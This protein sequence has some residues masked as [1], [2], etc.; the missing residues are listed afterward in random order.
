MCPEECFA[1]TPRITN[2]LTIA[3]SKYCRSGGRQM[4]CSLAR[5]AF[6][7]L[8]VGGALVDAPVARADGPRTY[9][10]SGLYIGANAGYARGDVDVQ[11]EVPADSTGAYSRDVGGGLFGFHVGFQHQW[12]SLVFGVEGS[13][14]ASGGDKIDQRGPDAPA[15]PGFDSYARMNSLLMLGGRLGWT[16][17]SN[18]LLYGAG[19]WANAKVETSYIIT[20]I[21]IVADQDT[22]R[23]NG[24][25]VGGGVEY[26]L[27]QSVIVGV[28]YLHVDLDSKIHSPGLGAFTTRTV[29]PD[30]DIVRARISFKLGRPEAVE[31]LK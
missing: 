29:D 21:I 28:E 11:Y 3:R 18:W 7:L 10:W 24:F 15:F 19:G 31:P 20:P 4:T 1:D 17:R 16:P 6:M 22:E 13:Y 5:A 8:L 2:T 9:N 30:I 12:Q 26:A 25:Y 23:H 27:T 14:S